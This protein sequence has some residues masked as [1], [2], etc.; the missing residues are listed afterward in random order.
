M[1]R[2][3]MS[4]DDLVETLVIKITARRHHSSRSKLAGRRRRF[5][6]VKGFHVGPRSHDRKVVQMGRLLIDVIPQHAVLLDRKSVV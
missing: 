2:G 1:M 4:V 6:G 3:S 5:I